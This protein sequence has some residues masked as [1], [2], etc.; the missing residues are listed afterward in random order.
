MG[1]PLASGSETIRGTS[2]ALGGL[3]VTWASRT[4]QPGKTSPN[5]L[6]AAAMALAL[7]LGERHAAP[8]RLTVGATVTLDEVDGAPGIVSSALRVHGDVPGLDPA[9]F[10]AVDEAALLCPV[11][12]LFAGAGITVESVPEPG[13]PGS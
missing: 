12:R 3:E 1:G 11:S 4:A 10:Q 9:G 6:A 2:G 8:R 5:E 13:Q 7:R